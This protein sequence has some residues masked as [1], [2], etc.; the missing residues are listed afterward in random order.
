MSESPIPLQY[1]LENAYPNPFNPSTTIKFSLPEF[2]EVILIIYN[3]KG[4]VVKNLINKIYPPGVHR[5]RWDAEEQ[6]S[7]MYFL[8]FKTDNY[9]RNQK[10][11]LIK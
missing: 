7:G 6:A 8:R 3:A 10:L 1:N 11:I 5:L 2:S 9:T 4:Q